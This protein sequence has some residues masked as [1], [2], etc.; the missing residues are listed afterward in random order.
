MKPI[1]YANERYLDSAFLA[2]ADPTR[3]AILARLTL[4]PAS[5]MEVAA[6]FQMSQPAVTKHLNVLER[7][8]LISRTRRGTRRECRAEMKAVT[9]VTAWLENYRRALGANFA[10][11]DGLL[12]EMKQKERT[13]AETKSIEMPQVVETGPIQMATLRAKVPAREIQMQMGALL[14]ELS[15][16]IQA[17]GVQVTGPWFTH[18]FRRPDEFFDFELCIPVATPVKASGRVQPGEWPTMKV[19]RTVYTGP[20]QGL[21]AGWGEFLGEIEKMGISISPEI[22]ERYLVGPD[23]ESDPEKWRTELNRPVQS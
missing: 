7:A 9:E 2:L 14:R 6:P 11:L 16:E 21:A 13:M 20:Y 3:R 17:Q 10:R 8:G 1:G 4:G 19:V 22:W 15:D 12:E 5:V 18:H 23:T